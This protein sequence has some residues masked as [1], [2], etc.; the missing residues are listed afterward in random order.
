MSPRRLALSLCLAALA[1]PRASRAQWL[2]RVALRPSFGATMMLS[3]HQRQRL[4]Y[5]LGLASA[6]TL[7]VD[8]TR[9]VGG[10]ARVA[11]LWFPSGRGDGEALLT[12]VGPRVWATLGDPGRPW[13]ELGVG[14][15]V[16]GGAPR[17]AFDAAL[18]WDF[19]V[20]PA[21]SV[22]PFVRY[23]QLVAA[24]RD[25]PTDAQALS[26]GAQ[27]SF[28]AP[29]LQGVVRAPG[30]VDGD[31]DGVEDPRDVCPD[32]SAGALP[33]PTRPGCPLNDRDLD[34]V[35]DRDDDCPNVPSGP[36]PDPARPGCPLPA[37][38]AVT[39]PAVTPAAPAPTS[40]PR[41]VAWR[42]ALA[43]PVRFAA[44]ERALDPDG[45]AVVARMAVALAAAP[46]AVRLV[47]E[48]HADPGAEREQGAALGTQRAQAVI[49]ALVEHGVDR[50][51]MV[52]RTAGISRPLWSPR[53]EEGR[54]GNRRVE[55][56]VVG[57]E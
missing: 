38:T 48:G 22:G 19:S 41:T 53:T 49:D 8:A 23:A 30:R 45:R 6:L 37:P 56:R 11:H 44:S 42:A 9:A 54:R 20:S 4:D 15:A 27:V 55:L 14:V 25:A 32:L 57:G 10:F 13:A 5:G 43:E 21:V 34:R 33:D 1:V 17:F 35:F 7:T 2:R 18:G 52:P 28:Q 24:E 12:T 36:R 16:T 39:P 47:V 26:L 3:A 40:R 50:A 31:G 29:A 46:E 51:R